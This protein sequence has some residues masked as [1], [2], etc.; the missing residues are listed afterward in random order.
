MYFN[1]NQ[2]WLGGLV[3]NAGGPAPLRL[4]TADAAVVNY[5]CLLFIMKTG[6]NSGYC[7]PHGLEAGWCNHTQYV[8]K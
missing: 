4:V 3:S 2:T 1:F 7:V 6:G 5:C 8:G